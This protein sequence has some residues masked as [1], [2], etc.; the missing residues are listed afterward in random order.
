MKQPTK[1]KRLK[2]LVDKVLEAE[3][4]RD[5]TLKELF[6]VGSEINFAWGNRNYW[7]TVTHHGYG[8][9]LKVRNDETSGERWIGFWNIEN[10]KASQ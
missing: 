7:G 3:T 2:A 6:P 8:M 1:V 4:R 9:R 5:E 10:A